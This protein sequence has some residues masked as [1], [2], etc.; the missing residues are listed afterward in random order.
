[1][2]ILDTVGLQ[3]RPIPQELPMLCKVPKDALSHF[4]L[5]NLPY[6]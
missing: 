3:I 4:F 6:N 1:M 5:G 2:L